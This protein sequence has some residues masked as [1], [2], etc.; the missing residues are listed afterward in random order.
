MRHRYPFDALHWLRHQRVDQRAAAVNERAARTTQA[1]RAELGAVASRVSTQQ[2]IC[3]VAQAEHAR[4]NEGLMRA[5][6]LQ[7]ED[8]WRKGANADLR[9]KAERE[10]RA[11]DLHATEVAAEVLARR[12]LGVASNEAKAIDAHRGAFRAECA[13]S[14]ERS[15]E[16]AAAEQWTARHFSMRRG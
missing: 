10:Q 2:S 7:V 14:Q 6:E 1:A 3:A 16:E 15:D 4:L 8:D 13:A 5:G 11:R 9:D 12:A